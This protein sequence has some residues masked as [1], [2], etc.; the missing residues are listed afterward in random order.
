MTTIRV[1]LVNAA[2]GGSMGEANM[3]ADR[4]PDSFDAQTTMHLGNDEW[5]VVTA[6]P[7]SRAEYEAAGRLRITLHKIVKVDPK[8]IL[9]SLPT[10][11]N[12][13]PP[14]QPGAGATCTMHEDDW[15]QHEL[16]SA[17]LEPEI[18]AE[19]GDIRT[20]HEGRVGIGFTAIHVRNRVPEPLAGR[21]I[22]LATLV[23]ALG[24]EARG[25]VS[26]GG[27]LVVGGFAY[28][29]GGGHVYGREDGGRI[30]DLAIAR[31]TDGRGLAPFARAHRLVLVNWCGA[32]VERF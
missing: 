3:P 11:E 4:L 23:E 32:S 5:Q 19:L 12:T 30:K 17:D 22:E 8:S 6:E 15:R 18:A 2:T 25:E 10:I 16:V 29:I 1:E 9:F 26:L 31:G 27:G 28:A 24:T 20:V 21:T 7:M 14:L 13:M